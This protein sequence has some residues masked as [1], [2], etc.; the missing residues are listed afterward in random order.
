MNRG[1]FDTVFGELTV[2][3]LRDR[4]PVALGFP[5]R[6]AAEFRASIEELDAMVASVR[7]WNSAVCWLSPN[8]VVARFE[9]EAVGLDG[10]TVR[11]DPSLS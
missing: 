6:S 7:T 5:D 11:M 8:W 1:D 4:E 10:E 9:R 3:E 2:P